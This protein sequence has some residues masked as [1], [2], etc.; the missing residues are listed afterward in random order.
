MP[1]QIC[2]CP[3]AVQGDTYH[4]SLFGLELRPIRSHRA[5]MRHQ[6]VVPGPVD[7]SRI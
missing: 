3:V 6:H 4:P 5:S 1:N 2:T 7:L